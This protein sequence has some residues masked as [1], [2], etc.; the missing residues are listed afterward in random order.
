MIEMSDIGM[1]DSELRRGKLVHHVARIE[2]SDS[3]LWRGK[4]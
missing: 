1:S 4:H 2:M 3:E